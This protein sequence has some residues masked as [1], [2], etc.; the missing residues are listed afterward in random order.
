M[1][2]LQIMNVS[3][4]FKKIYVQ[5][6]YNS[7]KLSIEHVC[8]FIVLLYANHMTLEKKNICIYLK[9]LMDRYAYFFFKRNN[10]FRLVFL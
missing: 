7:L 5:C 3:P 8:M 9:V 4:C 1:S 2:K 6:V 10:E